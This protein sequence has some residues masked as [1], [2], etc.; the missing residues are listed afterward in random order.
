MMREISLLKSVEEIYTMSDIWVFHGSDDAFISRHASFPHDKNRKQKGHSQRHGFTIAR[1]LCCFCC[2]LFS[3][4]QCAHV[5]YE[6]HYIRYY[7]NITFT[8]TTTP[9]RTG[10]HL[11]KLI[12]E[13]NV[14]F[15]LHSLLTLPI[16]CSQL[17]TQFPGTSA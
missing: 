11:K 15:F 12:L 10:S 4:V 13:A 16:T 7:L 6:A 1:V 2:F 3:H 17:Y 14:V 8:T 9:P 5:E